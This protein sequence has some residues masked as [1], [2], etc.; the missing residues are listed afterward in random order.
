M[1]LTLCF[2]LL[3]GMTRG[4]SAL[5][6]AS[7]KSKRTTVWVN[8]TK[9]TVLDLLSKIEIKLHITARTGTHSSSRRT[10]ERIRWR[11]AAS[12]RAGMRQVSGRVG[13]M[14]LGRSVGRGVARRGRILRRALVALGPAP[15]RWCAARFECRA[16]GGAL[17]RARVCAPSPVDDKRSVGA[18]FA[19]RGSAGDGRSP[20]FRPC[21]LSPLRPRPRGREFVTW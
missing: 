12:T 18:F 1:K 13:P 9:L 6:S 14:R 15:P 10:K 20:R 2:Y 17:S 4:R 8:Q 11:L 19:R 3:K 7:S 21:H 5:I 16:H